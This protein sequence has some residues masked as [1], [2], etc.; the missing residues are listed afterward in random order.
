MNKKELEERTK[1]FALQIIRFVSDLP[2]S[3]VTD[4]L[5]YQ[6]LKSGTSIGANHREANRAESRN[7]FIHKLLL[8]R[9]KR[10]RPNT[11]WNS[12]KMRAL[13]ILPS[14]IGWSK[15]AVNSWPYSP[16]RAKLLRSIAGE[17]EF[18][19]A[20]LGLRIAQQQWTSDS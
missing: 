12:S 5:G 11:G 10:L 1:R 19:I 18:T 16:H 14:V 3:K 7:D 6:L 15:N 8:S 4:V 20:K 13:A 2:R 9:K 17:R